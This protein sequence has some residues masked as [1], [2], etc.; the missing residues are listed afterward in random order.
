MGRCDGR[1]LRV[2]P[3]TAPYISWRSQRT[4]RVSPPRCRAQGMR[5]GL[6]PGDRRPT[7]RMARGRR[8]YRHPWRWRSR[9]DGDALLSFDHDHGLRAL[10]I[11]T[12]DEREAEQPRF[13]LNQEGTLSSWMS[14]GVFSPGNQFLA[15]SSATTASVAE[16]TTGAERFSTPS[17]ATA[18]T[19]DGR[20][21]AIATPGKPAMSPLADGSYRTSGPIA[22]GIDLVDLD[23]GKRKRLAIPKDTVTAMAFTPDGKVVAVAGGWNNPIVRLYR[24]DDGRQIGS[25]TCPARVTHAGGLAFSPDGRSLA[26]GLDDTTVL[27]WDVGD[28]R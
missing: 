6:G 23:T 21:L 5:V 24:C 11:A 8:Q 9:S 20:S 7:T 12:G 10:E 16:L 1:Q 2:I 4:E 13:G 19:P 28:V 26:A 3:H 22:D 18:F 17:Y 27:I 14:R 15:V 25:F